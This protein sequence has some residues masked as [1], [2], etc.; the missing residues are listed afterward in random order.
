MMRWQAGWLP[1][2]YPST[3]SHSV[4]ACCTADAGRPCPVCGRC[5][6]TLQQLR[7]QAALAESGVL[8]SSHP[9]LPCFAGK[10]GPSYG[11]IPALAKQVGELS[12]VQAAA[13][14]LTCT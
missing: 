12:A 14:R 6:T 11:S 2:C 5:S 3:R 9:D 10:T 13:M 7:S 1:P 4:S 8:T